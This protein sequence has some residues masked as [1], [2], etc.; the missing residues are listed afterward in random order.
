MLPSKSSFDDET[1][2]EVQGAQCPSRLWVRRVALEHLVE[3]V[4]GFVALPLA[5]HQLRE[6]HHQPVLLTL[7]SDHAAQRDLA[8][9]VALEREVHE[10]ELEVGLGRRREIPRSESIR[11]R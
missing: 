4:N 7:A 6:I 10:R 3:I 8:L 1:R 9:W 5:E 2:A 11:P